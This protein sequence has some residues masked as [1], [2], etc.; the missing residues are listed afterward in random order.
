MATVV[1]AKRI[2]NCKKD[3]IDHR[4]FILKMATPTPVVGAGDGS[5]VVSSDVLAAP[6]SIDLRALCPAVYDQGNLGSCVSNGTGGAIQFYQNKTNAEHKFMPSRLFM[7]Y[8]T[9]VIENCV[10]EDSG[11]TI[12]DCLVSVNKSGVCPEILW[13]YIE[14][15]FAVKPD[16]KCYTSAA[17]HLVKVY[18]RIVLDLAQMKQCLVDGYPFIFGIDLVSSF[19]DVGSNGNVAAPTSRDSLLGGHCMMCVGYNDSTQRFI[20]RNSWGTSWGDHGDC[21]IPY[22]YMTNAN[23]T[24]DLWTIRNVTDT[25]NVVVVPTTTGA[26][27]TNIRSA[28]YGKGAKTVNVTKQFTDYFLTH[29]QLQVENT[30]FGDPWRGVVKQLTITFTSG[31]SITYSEHKIVLLTTLL[32]YS[33]IVVKASNVVSAF[34]GSGKTQK[35]VTTIVKDYFSKGHLSMPVSNDL[36]GDP[37][38][39]VVKKLTLTLIGG[40]VKTFNERGVLMLEDLA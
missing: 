36:F 22:S 19:Y 34:Y 9:R 11:T 8:N 25:E 13:P 35:D 5:V 38:H 31:K 23:Y 17:S 7:Y 12:R 18:T 21:Y 30:L 29:T 1:A 40:A 4:D 15:K 26:V 32:T 39:G 10:S 27:L 16:T 37:I 2:F 28:V 33:T 3:P 24:S 6:A 14:S 20:V